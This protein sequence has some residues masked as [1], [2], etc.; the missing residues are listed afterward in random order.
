V[1]YALDVPA[2]LTPDELP[3][4]VTARLRHR[5]RSLR[6]QAAT[7]AAARTP[8]GAQFLAGARGARDVTIDPCKPQPVTL[9]AETRVELGA[10]AHPGTRPAWE[11]SYEHGM[12]LTQTIVTR[13]GEARTVLE[14]ALAR[15]PDARAQAMVEVQLGWVASKLGKADEVVTRV[16]RARALLATPPGAP[17]P[18]VF[19]ALLADA[20]VRLNRWTDALEP[21]RRCSEAAPKNAAAWAVYARVLVAVGD[22]AGALAA[23]TRGLEL[24]PRDPDLL[25]SQATALAALG[26]PQATAAEAAFDRFRAPDNWATLRI[27]CAKQDVRCA[28]E[29]NAVPTLPLR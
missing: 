27:T 3:L 29:R 7:C 28:R 10:G 17:E 16:A 23:A 9:I 22:H 11:R 25:R 1:R 4:A 21:A 24:A 2:G 14:A 20:F 5:S 15:A 26:D 19:D 18:P 13:L 6:A 12:A 8:E